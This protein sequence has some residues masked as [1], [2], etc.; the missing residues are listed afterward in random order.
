MRRP[1]HVST[2][3]EESGVLGASWIYA[4]VFI[5]GCL[6]G[7]GAGR[8]HRS[9]MGGGAVRTQEA[10]GHPGSAHSVSTRIL[11]CARGGA[12]WGG[13]CGQRLLSERAQGELT[14]KQ[15]PALTTPGGSPSR[16]E[17]VLTLHLGGFWLPSPSLHSGR[18]RP[19][20]TEPPEAW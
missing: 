20:L 7:A 8:Q 18:G 3:S 5:T 15:H 11:V 14:P 1:A 4:A 6:W 13:G 19:P 2:H 10:V 12:R 17:P 9:G 16:G